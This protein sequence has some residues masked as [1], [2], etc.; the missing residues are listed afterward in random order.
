MQ[1]IIAHI[2]CD[3]FYASVEI[4][5]RPELANRPIAVGGSAARRGVIS[6]CNYVARRFGV[7][8]AMPSAQALRACPGLLILPPDMARYRRASEQVRE[9]MLRL[10]DVIEPLSLDEAFLDL[11][12]TASDLDQALEAVQSLRT[13]VRAEVGITVSAGIADCKFLAKIASD[14][15]KPDGVHVVDPASRAAF[16]AALPL[17]KLPGVGPRSAERLEQDALHTCADVLARDTHALVRRHGGLGARLARLARGQDDRPVRRRGERK[18]LSVEETFAVDAT[19]ATLRAALERL[20][21]QLLT[22]ADGDRARRPDRTG[23][24]IAAFVKLRFADFTGTTAESR[25]AAPGLAD[26]SRL[27]DRALKRGPGAVRLLG[28]GLRYGARAAG[29]SELFPAPDRRADDGSRA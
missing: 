6:T 10:T 9:I 19:S 17:R 24:V 21:R 29:Q 27:L 3:C 16:I 4:R 2:D 25:A 14:W 8:S 11:G 22:R 26:F 15:N 1:R 28:V 5:D 23:P 20:V 12:T 13:A 18:S 7:H